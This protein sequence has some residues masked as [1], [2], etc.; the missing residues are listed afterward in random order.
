MIVALVPL[1]RSEKISGQ[2]IRLSGRRRQCKQIPSRADSWKNL[3]IPRVC[4][5]SAGYAG[6]SPGR[7]CGRY[8]R[9]SAPFLGTLLALKGEMGFVERGE[10]CY[11]RLA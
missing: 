3:R 11:P 5:R 8:G 2:A 6:E 10:G 7:Q 9:V 4:L 1:R